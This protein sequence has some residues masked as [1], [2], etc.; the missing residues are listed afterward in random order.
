MEKDLISHCH[1]KP[2][3]IQKLPLTGL[4]E[5]KEKEIYICSECT[6]E[7]KALEKIGI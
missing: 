3:I 1:K 6:K 5:E 4:P 2:V 7:C